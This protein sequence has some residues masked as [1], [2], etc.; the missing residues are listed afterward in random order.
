MGLV[1]L[2]VMGAVVASTAPAHAV[3]PGGPPNPLQALIDAASSGD[4][5]DVPPGVYV[6]GIDFHGKDILLRAT[7]GPAVTTI[8][9]NH[10]TGV[11]MGPDGVFDGFTVT[12]SSASFGAGMEIHGVGS[13]ITNSVFEGNHQGAGGF[14]A[15]IGGNGASP[16]ITGNR[17]VDNDCDGQ[18]LS[19]VLGFVNASHPTISNN[20]FVDNA[21]R[22]INVTIPSALI[23][24]NTIVGNPVA[25]R[26]DGRPLPSAVVVRNNV[27]VGNGIGLDV[28]FGPG[29][30]WDH[31]LVWGNTVDFDE[32]ADPTGTNGNLR[33]DPRVLDLAGR[34]LHVAGD[35]PAIDAGHPDG[36]PDVDLDRDV[37]PFDGNVDGVNL[38]DLGA[39]ER[40]PDQRFHPLPPARIV[41]TRIAQGGVRMGEGE[42]LDVAVLGVGGVPT[43]GVAAVAVNLTVVEPSAAT[44]VS[45]WPTGGSRPMSSNI[46]AP[47]GALI[48]NGAQLRV[49]DGG[50]ISLFNANGSVDVLVDVV[51]WF[52]SSGQVP[53]GRYVAIAPNRIVDT[54]L[55]LGGTPLGPGTT[56]TIRVTGTA[57]V[58]S[59]GV[60]AV[61]INLTAVDQDRLT[62]FSVWASGADRPVASTLNAR[63][64]AP[65]P[66]Q[67]VV[68]VSDSGDIDL[69]N[70][71][72]TANA[73]VDV[74]GYWSEDP[75]VADGVFVPVT[76][77]RSLDTRIGL[78]A[79]QQRVV[80]GAPIELS[81]AE[82]VGGPHIPVR[83]VA[84]NITASVPSHESL[85]VAYPGGTPRPGT[86]NLNLVPGRD[87]AGFAIVPVG[88]DGTI[89]LDNSVGDVDLVVDV[90]GWYTAP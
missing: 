75:L 7:G 26:V 10:G 84:V 54:R 29:P 71:A 15:A 78:G 55:G 86:S 19:G 12:N 62:Y 4:T 51:G 36:A 44:F 20:E 53:G 38:P 73:V 32:F 47:A 50:R 69:Y 27:I 37:R 45:A 40:R 46:N 82:V 11:R 39:Y 81:F 52:D 87:V 83:A 5:I 70:A 64:G 25:I 31:N 18:W 90:L 85:V 67:A 59:S 6:G 76:P 77:T 34:D 8:D 1:A 33:A 79:P 74:V 16:T 60:S 89:M 17:F 41:D 28:D 14:G 63:P 66:N 57:G 24:N 22:A 3:D 65:T 43:S 48:A 21:C 35:S 80:A 9:G 30:T 49:G 56:S 23:V 2:A 68:E 13:L 61:A 88:A 72:G 42:T 58:P